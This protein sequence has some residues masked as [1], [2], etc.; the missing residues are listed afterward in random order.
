MET[1]TRQPRQ[2]D[3][4]AAMLAMVVPVVAVAAAVAAVAAAVTAPRRHGG[5]VSNGSG[6][7][8]SGDGGGGGGG[9]DFDAA[10]ARAVAAALAGARVLAPAPPSAVH[11]SPSLR[12]VLRACP[13]RRPQSLCSKGGSMGS[14]GQQR[15]RE[16]MLCKGVLMQFSWARWKMSW[17]AGR[18]SAGAMVTERLPGC[19][20]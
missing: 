16:W 1:V 17:S 12:C 4:A 11:G 2:T 13:T 6:S 15:L 14:G 9:A 19:V 7:G 10:V 5:G 20:P 18:Q 8:R 3:V